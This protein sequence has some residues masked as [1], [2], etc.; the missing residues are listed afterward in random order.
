MIYFDNAATTA[1]KPPEV[2]K[3]VEN[4][5]R[6]YSANPGRSGHALSIKTAEEIY[7][8]RKKTADFFG[9]KEAENVVFTMNCTEA[10]NFVIKGVLS[11]GD[12]VIIS[13]LEHNAVLR[14][15]VKT[16]VNFDVA[17]VDLK[18]DSKT[19][20]SF[21]KLFRPNTKL[22]V[23]TAASN[24]FGK[25]LPIRA[26]GKLCRER[27]ALFAVDG[28]QGGGVIPLD[29]QKD[30][31]DFLCLAPHKGFY[32]PMGLG[33][34]IAKKYI[35]NTVIEG[36]T[37]TN[38]AQKIQPLELPERLESGTLCVPAIFGFSAGL[39]FV[40]K[41]GIEKI[42]GGEFSLIERLYK[43]IK[44][45]PWIRLYTPEPTKGLYVPVLSFNYSGFSSEET[46][47]VLDKK[48]IAVRAGLHCAP[49]AHRSLWTEDTGTVRVSV[50]AFNNQS[51][52]DRLISVLWDQ[53]NFKNL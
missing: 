12:H 14:P 50:S 34:L 2:I 20:E 46:A 18:E 38:S 8:I 28:A 27:G 24:V 39:D 6:N 31:I 30:N 19:I 11:R 4:A 5:L 47:A 7:R 48:G 23:C 22:V 10:L 52:I 29:M 53:K 16:G 42:Y 26:I 40:K 25:I 51:E 32:A 9:A 49:L 13:S 43:Q 44:D 35:P 45:L 33:V 15:L 37:G 36:G 17:R 21:K 1:N 3:A 41:K